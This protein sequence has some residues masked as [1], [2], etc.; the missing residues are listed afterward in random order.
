MSRSA[1]TRLRLLL[2]AAGW[3]QAQLARAVSELASELHNPMRC[4]PS[5]VSRWLAGVRPRPPA[6]AIL[7]EAFS[8]RL[9][10]PVTAQEAGL[11]RAPA[12]AAVAVPPWEAD[13]VRALAKLTTVELDPARRTVLGASAFS[14]A[15]LIVP[16]LTRAAAPR[17]SARPPGS[18][19]ATGHPPPAQIAQ[20][21][22]MAALFANA[23]QQHGGGGVRPALAAYL[24]HTVTPW[25]HAPISD[26]AHARLL[27]AAAQLTLLL[28]GMCADDGDDNTAQ[29]YQRTALRMALDGGDDNTAAIVLRTMST[30][31][32]ELGHRSPH[33]LN[34]AE[35]AARFARHGPLITQ[36]YVQ[37]QLAVLQAHHDRRGALAALSRA[38]RLHARAETTPGPFTSYP[39]SALH[40]QRAHTLARLGDTPT[41]ITAL[42]TSIRLRTDSECHARALTRAHLAEMLLRHGHLEAALP[43]W[44]QF[45]T[46][47]PA[48]NSRRAHRRLN[49]MRQLL[50]PHQNHRGAA[51]LLAPALLFP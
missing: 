47:Y 48:L 1:N 26:A 14:L 49:A 12:P 46:D 40:Y 50:R 21:H 35:Q 2:S 16:D 29:H 43:H 28:A 37:A 7:T 30:H 11:T 20:M 39:A 32:H 24:A 9:G 22:A 5:T 8:R 17:P 42:T 10:R 34:L 38:E 41:A 36:A 51:D 45:L 3:S 31:A 27:A 19:S 18:P 44:R 25:L 13:P 4:D 33:V 6:P 23:A 15:A